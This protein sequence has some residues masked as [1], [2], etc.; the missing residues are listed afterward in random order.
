MTPEAILRTVA[1]EVCD[2]LESYAEMYDEEDPE[3]TRLVE[4]A[5]YLERAVESV[6][7]PGDGV[8]DG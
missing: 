3:H 1:Y 7:G 2:N 8:A 6:L 4:L 5:K